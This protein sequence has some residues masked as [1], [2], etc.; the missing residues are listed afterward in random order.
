MTSFP[1]LK[2]LSRLRLSVLLILL[3]SGELVAQTPFY[4]FVATDREAQPAPANGDEPAPGVEDILERLL[5]MSPA[6]L[7]LQQAPSYQGT[8]TVASL[9]EERVPEAPAVITVVTKEDI[10]RYGARHLR[11]VI[12][13]MPN[14]QVFGNQFSS[15]NRTSM[16]AVTQTIADTNILL[17]LNGRPIR[18]SAPGG[19]NFDIYRNFPLEAI[20]RL[21]VIRGPGSV[22]YGTNA[23][24]G[25]INIVTRAPS[26]PR[27]VELHTTVGSFGRVH[28]NVTAG[29]EG[30]QLKFFA[31]VNM[32][33]ND[34]FRV[35]NIHDEVGGS[36]TYP[37]GANGTTAFL[38]ASYGNWT[39]NTILSDVS[40]DNVRSEFAFPT[41]TIELER[42][43]VDVGYHKDLTDVLDVNFNFT[44]NH[45]RFDFVVNPAN[46]RNFVD[47]QDYLFE[48]TSHWNPTERFHLLV[49]ANV[50]LLKGYFDALPVF[51]D[52]WRASF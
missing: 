43:Y 33:N 36:G 23:F 13:R 40:K 28:G 19:I 39:V 48:A 44:F 14:M 17:L 26:C 31:S 15:H 42:R 11:D 6:E 20:E 27:E 21:E 29:V 4:E 30:P 52:T 37:F 45:A 10:R 25:V 22:L 34:G 16:R 1:I 3:T 46:L 49:G 35:P 38:Q 47:S 7:I 51:Y 12:D 18:D 5:E 9:Q 24:S 50:D 41:T 8:I 2:E 32:L